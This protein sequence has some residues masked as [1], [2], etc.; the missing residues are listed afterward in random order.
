MP[1]V[2]RCGCWLGLLVSALLAGCAGELED[3]D[4]FPPPECFVRDF[5][6]PRDLFAARCAGSGC[7]GSDMPAANLDLVSSGVAGRLLD[8]SGVCSGRL[9]DT[10]SVSRSLLLDKVSVVPRCGQAMPVDAPPLTDQEAACLKVWVQRV[11]ESK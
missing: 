5:Q 3:P 9:I 1:A 6:A 10:A 8:T 7:H 11:A 4:R 2:F